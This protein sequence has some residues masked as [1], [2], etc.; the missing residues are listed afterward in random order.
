MNAYFSVTKLSLVRA[1][2][3]TRGR[4]CFDCAAYLCMCQIEC[5]RRRTGPN[6][7][8]MAAC[9]ATYMPACVPCVLTA[10]RRPWTT[11]HFVA[12]AVHKLSPPDVWGVC[13][14]IRQFSAQIMHGHF[15][16]NSNLAPEWLLWFEMNTIMEW[17]ICVNSLFIHI[18]L[19]FW[20]G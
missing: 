19:W 8:V 3:S 9:A 14:C 7:F 10:L 20:K 11:S 1:G 5:A 2:T 13:S 18:F 17:S 16:I 15:L 6:V 4:C 12:P